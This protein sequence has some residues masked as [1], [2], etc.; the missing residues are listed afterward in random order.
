VVA[1]IWLQVGG[2]EQALLRDFI[3][4]LATAHGTVAF[5]PHLTVCT[6]TA[7]TPERG[8]TAADYIANCCALPFRVRKAKL[9]YSTTNPFQAIVIDIENDAGIR[10]FREG[11]RLRTGAEA[12]AK[13]HISLLYT[14]DAGERPTPWAGDEE[15]LGEIAADC[16]KRLAATRFL[17]ER[18]I[19]V[20]PDGDWA[21]IKSWT[22]LREF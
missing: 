7:P 15:R 3:A 20:A 6:I 19:L 18:P 16:E 14:V 12:L 22:T 1:S 10:N 2:S 13:P 11:L 4:A 9:S 8:D 21:N 17:L 5:E